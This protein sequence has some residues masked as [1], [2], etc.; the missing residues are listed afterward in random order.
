VVKRESFPAANLF[1]T[2]PMRDPKSNWPFEGT[3]ERFPAP[4]ESPKKWKRVEALLGLFLIF[5]GPIGYAL[6]QLYKYLAA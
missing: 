4:G 3:S 2:D 1:T 5:G 6:V